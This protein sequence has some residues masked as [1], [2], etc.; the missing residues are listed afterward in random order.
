MR[1]TSV[2]VRSI[3]LLELI[4]WSVATVAVQIRSSRPPPALFHRPTAV[5]AAPLS[6]SLA[7]LSDVNPDVQAQ[8]QGAS[9]A[10]VAAPAAA[11]ADSSASAG[12]DASR[13]SAASSAAA[14]PDRAGWMS[15]NSYESPEE[16]TRYWFVLADNVL[17]FADDEVR[18][19][20]DRRAR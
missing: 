2:C 14:V 13:P 16:F 9:P 6:D 3:V 8:P 7:L 20:A 4:R 11:A 5:M 18:H 17:S 10:A 12:S 19:T 15:M 1:S